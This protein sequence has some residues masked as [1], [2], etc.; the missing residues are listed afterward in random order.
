MERFSD[1]EI[2]LLLT[3][4]VNSQWA[5]YNNVQKPELRLEQY[6]T[7]IRWYL[8]HTPFRIVVGENSGCK[9]LKDHFEPEFQKRI[10]LICFVETNTTRNAGYNEM[11]I[12]HRIKDESKFIEKSSLVFKITGRLIV[13][14]IMSH[15]RQLRNKQGDFFAAH[16]FRNLLYIDSRFFAFTTSKYDEIL[17]LEDECCAIH[18]D[19]VKAGKCKNGENGKYVDFESTIGAV[20]KK[21]LYK[22]IDSFYYLRNPFIISGVE[23][24]YGKRYK[25]D[26]IFR[27]KAYVKSFMWYLDW[28]LLVKPSIKKQSTVGSLLLFL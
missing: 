27:I 20:I 5:H 18:W 13:R 4:T 14:N 2:V 26:F 1:N 11:L 21:S 7:A 15:V 28:H 24:F 25:D 23:G 6:V 12:L 3:A 19:D 17:A 16:L 9:D 10:E 22:E 8:E